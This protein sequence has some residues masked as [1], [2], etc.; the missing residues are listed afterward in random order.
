MATDDSIV[1]TLLL[2]IALV[3]LLPFLL[4]VLM[5]PTMGM[6]GGGH[7]WDGGMWNGTTGA[8]MGIVMWLVFLLV[9][10]GIGYLLY[11]AIQEPGD[12]SDAAIEELRTAYARGD[13]SEE[14]YENRRERLE[15]DR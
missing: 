10:L 13:L 14:E 4:M 5:A 6:W 7:M 9:I 2:I 1:R 11:R 12:E 15:R 8:W 3:L